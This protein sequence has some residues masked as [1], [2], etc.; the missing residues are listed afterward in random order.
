MEFELVMMEQYS[1]FGYSYAFLN[2]ETIS[3]RKQL[4]YV[5]MLEIIKTKT[6]ENREHTNHE[7]FC[8]FSEDFKCHLCI[9]RAEIRLTF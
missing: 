6:I 8:H 5:Y 3:L 9:P 7:E 2:K 1:L 4:F